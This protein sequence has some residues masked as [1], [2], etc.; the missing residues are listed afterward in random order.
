M[1][2]L[3]WTEQHLFIL[4]GVV[5][6]KLAYKKSDDTMAVKFQLVADELFSGKYSI[7][8]PHLKIQGPAV[9]RKFLRLWSSVKAATA[10]EEEGANLS[11]LPEEAAESFKLVYNMIVEVM[12]SDNE[13]KAVTEKQRQRN[14]QMLTHESSMLASALHRVA[15]TPSSSSDA[16][17][18]PESRGVRSVSSDMFGDVLSSDSEDDGNRHHE[19]A[20][21]VIIKSTP[22][23]SIEQTKA[24]DLV[25][26]LKKDPRMVEIELAE[27]EYNLKRRKQEDEAQDEERKRQRLKEDQMTAILQSLADFIKSSKEKDSNLTFF[28]SLLNII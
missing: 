25:S 13:K 15:A 2:G 6:Q 7:F 3:S 22:N 27:R 23:K 20:K 18:A 5:K 11:G 8:P 10:L 1:S 17:I 16:I 12:Q 19:V 14:N 4:A 26:L 9:N 24:V 21:K 28:I